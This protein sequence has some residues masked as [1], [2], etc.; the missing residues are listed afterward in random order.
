MQQPVST[1]DEAGY[2]YVLEFPGMAEVR[3]AHIQ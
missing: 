3:D 1:S 2:I